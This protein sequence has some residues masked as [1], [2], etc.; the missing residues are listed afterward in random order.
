MKKKIGFVLSMLLLFTVV[1]AACQTAEKTDTMI[2][3][4]ENEHYEFDISLADFSGTAS[5]LFKS[6]TESS[7]TYYKDIA[8]SSMEYPGNKDEILPDEA[9]G[10]YVV[11]ISTEDVDESYLVKTTKTLY[12]RYKKS[13]LTNL[14]DLQSKVAAEE[15]N[16]FGADNDFVTLKNTE[17]T[18][19][20]F[21][22]KQAQ[23]PIESSTEVS[24]FY[25]GKKHQAISDYKVSTVYN[26]D[27]K[28]AKVTVN[29][30]E[31]TH[32]LNV[33]TTNYIDANQLLLYIRTLEKGSTKF[34]D[35]PSVTLFVPYAGKEYTAKFVF[36]YSANV[37]LD[38]EGTGHYVTLNSVSVAL[39]GSP[40]MNQINL[41]DTLAEKKL[42]CGESAGK[43]TPNYTTVRFRVGY[44]SY[45]LKGIS[46][47]IL[48][49]LQATDAK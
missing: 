35:S 17:I 47:D 6:Y 16:P 10:T 40:Y 15:E 1:L 42:D 18:S 29:G 26:F 39:D 3:W 12:V 33:G 30:T 38:V 46:Q 25:V 49:G 28:T 37:Y 43:V 23:R 5:P 36:A 27:D 41:P 32:K 8:V 11:D 7:K 20:K 44:Y 13:D 31:T 9:K 21:E 19:V 4:G 34:Q 45:Q 48:T 22:K 14:S 24:G 2:R